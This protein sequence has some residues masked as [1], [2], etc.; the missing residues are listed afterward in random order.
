MEH[1]EPFAYFKVLPNESPPKKAT[2]RTISYSDKKSNR[3]LSEAQ[4]SKVLVPE[5]NTPRT[6]KLPPIS[7]HSS[8]LERGEG[9]G[10]DWEKYYNV[11]NLSTVNIDESTIKL[12]EEN[13]RRR[14]A[15]RSISIN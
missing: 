5:S 2:E 7:K 9:S 13:H 10:V 1:D 15:K 3:Y 14:K 4:V 8:V 12:I 11:H 6:V